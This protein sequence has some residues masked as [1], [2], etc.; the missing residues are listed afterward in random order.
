MSQFSTGDRSCVSLANQSRNLM[1]LAS[2]SLSKTVQPRARVARDG[3]A[4]LCAMAAAFS[5]SAGA[6]GRDAAELATSPIIGQLEACQSISEDAER[7]TC[8]DR[9]VVNLLGATR[10]GEVKVVA[11]EAITDARK[12]LFGFSLPK[13][14]LFGDGEEEELKN[15]TSTITKVRKVGRNE[16]YFWI[17]EGNAVWRMK[18]NS[19]G[20]RA[21]K[22]GDPV[23]F[24]PA[25]M[26]TYWIRVDGRNGVRGN[27]IE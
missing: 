5:V 18:N 4:I 15:L 11:T 23:E 25:S 10:D 27:R 2:P 22:V 21:P 8:F 26:N 19:I 17:E 20:A 12:R 14:G 6:Q 13:I 24:K 7:L 1:S 3:S 9:E 16:W